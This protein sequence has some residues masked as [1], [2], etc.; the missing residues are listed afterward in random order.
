MHVILTRLRVLVAIDT[1]RRQAQ[2]V[3]AA[4][5]RG[6][7]G[8]NRNCHWCVKAVNAAASLFEGNYDLFPQIYM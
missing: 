4:A 8:G 1:E 5:R 7:S 6:T 2:T 3:A